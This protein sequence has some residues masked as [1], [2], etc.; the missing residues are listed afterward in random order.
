[1]IL[2]SGAELLLIGIST[3]KQDFW[4]REHRSQL[5]GIVM[6]GV[7][8]AFN[9]HAGEV[10][11]APAWMQNSGLEWFFRLMMEPLRLWKRYLL[12]TPLFLP[13][14]GLQKLGILRFNNSVTE[15]RP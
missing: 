1:M 6:A 2:E 11:Q 10:R 3:P 8:A 5:R 14:W 9:F 13:L 4:M 15:P 12:V 7:G